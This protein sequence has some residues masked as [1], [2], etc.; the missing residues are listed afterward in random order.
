VSSSEYRALLKTCDVTTM[1]CMTTT[2]PL[3]PLHMLIEL[4]VPV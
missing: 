1:A 4:S 2:T 3:A